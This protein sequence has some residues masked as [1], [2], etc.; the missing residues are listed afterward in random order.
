MGGEISGPKLIKLFTIFFY[1]LTIY[2][3]INQFFYLK[4]TLLF[5]S[6]KSVCGGVLNRHSMTAKRT[7]L[8]PKIVPK[9]GK[10]IVSLNWEEK[11]HNKFCADIYPLLFRTDRFPIEENLNL[12]ISCV[13]NTPI[14]MDTTPIPIPSIF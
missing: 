13:S 12:N 3:L 14:P 6:I 4:Q 7:L 11:R 2:I 8:A 1:Y 9:V 10:F 5:K